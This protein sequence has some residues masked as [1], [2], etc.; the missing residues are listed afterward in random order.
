MEVAVPQFRVP[1][2][3]LDPLLAGPQL[4]AVYY[5]SEKPRAVLYQVIADNRVWPV[6]AITVSSHLDASHG[7]GAVL[8][9]AAQTGWLTPAS[10]TPDADKMT[11]AIALPAV[12]FV[13]G[14]IYPLLASLSDRPVVGGAE[15]QQLLLGQGLRDLGF[16]I[17]Y[18]TEDYGQGPRATVRG[19]PVLS[20]HLR[21]NKLIQGLTLI[22]ALWRAQADIYYVRDMPK[23]GL[24]IYLFCRTTRRK[25]V[26][27]L[28]DDIEAEPRNGPG[29]GWTLRAHAAW[30]RRA[31]L[32]IAQTRYQAERLQ[33]NW[34]VRPE[35]VPN[36]VPMPAVADRTPHPKDCFRVLWVGRLAP[37]KRAAWIAEIA[38]RLPEMEFVVV[39]ARAREAPD[40]Y[41]TVAPLLQACPNVRWLGFVPY[42]QV[43]EIFR[44]TD[45]LLHTSLP[46]REGF[47]NVFLQAWA[48]AIPVVSTGADPNA[49][50]TEGG[51]G[52]LTATVDE[53]V[54]ALQH[55][56]V[57]RPLCQAM[58][59][60]GRQFAWENYRLEAVIPRLAGLLRG[61]IASS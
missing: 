8:D 25:I 58:G 46:G 55:L 22:Q 7:P 57:D 28:A 15:V 29:G 2:S 33:T 12:C 30:R 21:R 50:L 48:A 17:S 19:F 20:F 3:L 36:V 60:R 26:Q 31:D 59:A 51:L 18:V 56:A 47:P 35:I 43:D 16:K 44:S 37:F 27:A 1:A 40:H 41:E 9:N 4:E 11:G 32:V 10:D 13:S 49:L 23:Y 39:G 24:L 45:V 61:L 34:G 6:Q 38:R 42:A 14:N 54:A 5:T 52:L 53:A